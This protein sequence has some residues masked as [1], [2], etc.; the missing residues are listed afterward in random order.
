LPFL[1]NQEKTGIKKMKVKDLLA[2]LAQVDQ[3]LEVALVY[4]IS[5]YWG[6]LFHIAEEVQVTN[7]QVDGPK[8][9]GQVCLLIK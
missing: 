4:D 6:E 8:N 9:L 7:V 2:Q 1:S 5:E 3:E